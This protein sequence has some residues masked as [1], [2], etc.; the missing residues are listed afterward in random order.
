MLARDPIPGISMRLG[1]PGAM[2]VDAEL[3]VRSG[4]CF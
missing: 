1:G 4:K 2:R 3:R